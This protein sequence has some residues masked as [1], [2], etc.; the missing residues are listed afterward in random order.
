MAAQALFMVGL[1]LAFGM[2]AWYRTKETNETIDGWAAANNLSVECA[3]RIRSF[4]QSY[5]ATV[6]STEGGIVQR[7]VVKVT[8]LG[9]GRRSLGVEPMVK[10]IEPLKPTPAPPR[11]P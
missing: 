11:L 3:E 5:R 10:W 4:R 6:W 1:L 8:I 9:G 2:Y 7:G